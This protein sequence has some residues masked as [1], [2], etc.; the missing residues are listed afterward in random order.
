MTYFVY[1]LQSLKDGRFYIDQT[2][3]IELRLE[4]YNSGKSNYT[5]KF[6]PWN[7]VWFRQHS[8]RKEAFKSEQD[9]KKLK[10]RKRITSLIKE[11]PC[12]PGT[13]KIQIS[14][15]IFFRESS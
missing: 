13:E 15:L 5:S 12:V 4:Q 10:S 3:N 9:I 7:L 11:N 14:D 6:T 2:Q 1:I 8:S